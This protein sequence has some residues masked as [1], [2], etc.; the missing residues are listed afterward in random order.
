MAA[1]KRKLGDEFT[2]TAHPVRIT[3]SSHWAQHWYED[4]L[5]EL[6]TGGVTNDLNSK[7][8]EIIFAV[9]FVESYLLEWARDHV[10][11]GDMEI[12]LDKIK[13]YFYVKK[14]LAEKWKKIVKAICKEEL[15]IKPPN[16][17]EDY[18]HEFIKLV[19][20]RHG[21]VHARESIPYGTDPPD[22]DIF[23][24]TSPGDTSKVK[25][26]WATRTVFNL[27]SKLHEVTD[28]KTGVNPPDWLRKPQLNN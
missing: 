14:G 24:M 11:V 28:I 25:V 20:Y 26:G 1:D 7:R 21:Y 4:A 18:W 10:F 12:K 13:K 27:I 22:K 9:C 5:N 23:R 2:V 8:R 15:N 16:F 17:N 6:R 19:D 3:L